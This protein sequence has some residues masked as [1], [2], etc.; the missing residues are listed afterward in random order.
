MG[1]V[2][3]VAKLK[4]LRLKKSNCDINRPEIVCSYMIEQF[5]HDVLMYDLGR[6][7]IEGLVRPYED[8]HC[9]SKT[10]LPQKTH[11]RYLD[12]CIQQCA[13]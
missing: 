4:M 11:M 1:S 3:I 13:W 10:W 7:G 2:F 8:L 12:E 6:S 5:N 9:P